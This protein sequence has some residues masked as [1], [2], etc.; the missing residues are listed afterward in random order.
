MA[1]ALPTLCSICDESYTDDRPS[2]ELPCQHTFCKPCIAQLEVD[3]TRMCPFCRKPWEQN[4]IDNSTVTSLN[5]SKTK[6][7]SDEHKK[8]MEIEETDHICDVHQLKVF[9]YCVTCSVSVCP[10][11]V[12]SNHQNHKFEDFDEYSPSI[13]DELERS[14]EIKL[15]ELEATDIKANDD[16]AKIDN[17]ISILIQFEEQILSCQNERREEKKNIEETKREIATRKLNLR[18][19]KEVASDIRLKKLP[20]LINK[21]QKMLA[22]AS[23]DVAEVTPSQSS[24]LEN[25]ACSY[26]VSA[27]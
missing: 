7:E 27:C 9:V 8:N 13:A 12:T 17:K 15:S 1:E 5:I 18:K 3:E 22:E 26:M 19:I 2:L 10:K 16:L 14:I 11:C 23:T 20:L 24:L 4:L 6:L 25:I 21:G